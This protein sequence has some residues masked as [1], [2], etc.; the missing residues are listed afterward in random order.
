MISKRI[1]AVAVVPFVLAGCLEK[2]TEP[3]KDSPTSKVRNSDPAD[4][5]EMPDG[6]SNLATK[7][8]GHGHRIYSAFHGDDNR[9]AL[10]VVVDP[11]CP[12]GAGNGT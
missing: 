3:F 9:A 5:I 4:V 12:G 10:A 11:T 8:D 2:H 1:L 7:C 6:F